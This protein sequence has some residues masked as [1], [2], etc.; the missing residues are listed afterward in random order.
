MSDVA[1]ANRSVLRS[2]GCE[3]LH[4]ELVAVRGEARDR[5]RSAPAVERLRNCCNEKSFLTSVYTLLS[6]YRFA[7]PAARC[8]HADRCANY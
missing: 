2:Q 8:R 3:E 1:C 4:G 6:L 7:V 5:P